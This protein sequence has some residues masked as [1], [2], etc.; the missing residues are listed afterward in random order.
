MN[1][2]IYT[3]IGFLKIMRPYQWIKNSLVFIPMIMAHNINLHS[4]LESALAFLILS[5]VASSI[6]II[7]DIVDIKSDRLH[8]QKK[9][10]PLAAETITL[11][12]SK[13]LILVLIFFS[14]LLMM[15]TNKNFHFLVIGYFGVSN[16]YTFVLKNI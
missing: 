6:Y 14:I 3:Y 4:F 10:R 9:F 13:F 15:Y 5:F 2:I 12:Q 7:N 1:K 11:R 16:L 8:P